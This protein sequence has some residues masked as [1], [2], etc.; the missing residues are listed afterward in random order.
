MDRKRDF[1]L[2]ACLSGTDFEDWVVRYGRLK[3]AALLPNGQERMTAAW[4]SLRSARMG[5]IS[6]AFIFNTNFITSPSAR[7]Y[8]SSAP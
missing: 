6:I 5:R 7:H 8:C 3:D 4:I 2:A 1:K